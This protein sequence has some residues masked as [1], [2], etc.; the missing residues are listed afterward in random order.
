V[1]KRR[2]ELAVQNNR[3]QCAQSEKYEDPDKKN[4][5]RG[6][7]HRSIDFSS[8]WLR[9]KKVPPRKLITEIPAGKARRNQGGG[10]GAASGGLDGG[11]QLAM[12]E[13]IAGEDRA[14]FQHG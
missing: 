5:G 14:F 12:N 1:Q 9:L 13:F 10:I 2:P 11:K 6:N 3:D 7:L 4:P 8:H